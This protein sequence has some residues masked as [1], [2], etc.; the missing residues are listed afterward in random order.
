MSNRLCA[1]GAAFCLIGFSSGDGLP[2]AHAQTNRL[3]SDAAEIVVSAPEGAVISVN[4]TAYAATRRVFTMSPFPAGRSYIYKLEAAL[5]NG[6]VKSRSVVLS[7]GRRVE[8]DFGTANQPELVVQSVDT[9]L[10]AVFSPDGHYLLASDGDA[11]TLLDAKTLRVLRRYGLGRDLDGFGFSTDGRQIYTAHGNTTTSS[12]DSELITWDRDSGR[13]VGSVQIGTSTAMEISPDHRY[14]ATANYDETVDIWSLS[15]GR[16]IRSLKS[17]KFNG[18]IYKIRFD[19]TGQILLGIPAPWLEEQKVC[20]AWEMST[21]SE[22]AVF[23]TGKVTDA[24]YN[25]SGKRLITIGPLSDTDEDQ[26]RIAIW[27]AETGELISQRETTQA[28]RL[29]LSS[30]DGELYILFREE[31]QSRLAR[32]SLADLSTSDLVNVDGYGYPLAVSR[33]AEQL[34][35]GGTLY[36]LPSLKSSTSVAQSKQGES[37]LEFVPGTDEVVFYGGESFNVRTGQPGK[38]FEDP[39]GK[40][41]FGCT[42]SPDGKRV[43]YR[44]EHEADDR[45]RILVFDQ[46]SRRLINDFSVPRFYRVIRTDYSGSIAVTVPGTVHVWECDTGQFRGNF[47]PDE[48]AFDAALSRDGRYLLTRA[49]TEYDNARNRFNHGEIWDVERKRILH[50]LSTT[51]DENYYTQA[52]FAISPDGRYAATGQAVL[53]DGNWKNSVVLLWDL[54][55]GRYIKT[56]S[57]YVGSRSALRF[58]A[59]S[60]RLFAEESSNRTG[61]TVWDVATGQSLMFDISKGLAAL[62]PDGDRLITIGPGQPLRIWDVDTQREL[63]RWTRVKTDADK[64]PTEWLA[65]TPEGLFDGTAVARREVAFRVGGG[66]NVVPADRFYQDFYYP[67]LMTAIDNGERPLPTQEFARVAAPDV[68]WVDKPSSDTVNELN[69]KLSVKV[70]DRGGGIKPPWLLHN[71]ARVI[72]PG[73][74][75]Q[76]GNQLQR[77]F[78]VSL[79]EGTNEIEVF[80]ASE[81]GSWE[82]EPARLVLNYAKPLANPTLHLVAVGVSQYAED[83]MR[84]RFAKADAESMAAM[85]QTR[86]PALYGDGNVKVTRVLD[87]DATREGILSTIGQVAAVAQPQDTFVLFLAGHGTMVGQRYYFLPHEFVGT[88]ERL[89]EDIRRQGL[90]GDEL[91]EALGKVP[92]LK[93]VLIY[94]TCQSGGAVALTRTARNPFAFRGALERMSRATGTFIIAATAASAEAHE[95]ED[96]EHGVLSYTLLAGAGAPVPGPLRNQPI[97]SPDDKTLDIREWFNY[98]QDKVPNITRLYL[99]EEQFVEANAAGSNFPLLPISD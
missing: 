61:A 79:V 50:T 62:N 94:D 73:E 95:I 7:R 82:S 23:S 20:V 11:A 15:N 65:T 78:T 44:G 81:D 4:G 58:S 75:Q 76:N 47:G 51:K 57:G 17:N 22:V 13:P 33:K 10:N 45:D 84:L 6:S 80:S 2:S 64:P 55:S 59:D 29:A 87:E 71:G 34:Y 12:D 27:N 38:S 5:P 68:E 74:S 53:N 85:F 26:S 54:Q 97:R 91:N 32:L 92:A 88:A 89:E 56:L 35:S 25:R 24:I 99:G 93:R 63:V 49:I 46:K 90:P 43:L 21:G 98:A 41:L 18:N 40:R 19:H 1:W 16:R 96:L 70:T 83:T 31:D 72:S 48:Y 60:R 8:V 86:G 69:V 39:N 14:A 52:S 9:G 66:L 42:V 28:R 36:D 3:A 37:D 77:S 30:N 67:G